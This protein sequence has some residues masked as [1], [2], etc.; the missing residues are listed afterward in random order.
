MKKRVFISGVT[1]TM[2]KSGLKHLLEHLDILEI[3]TLVRP[4]KTNKKIMSQ[5]AGSIDIIWGDLENYD[6]VKKALLNVDYILHVAALVSPMADSQP[7]LAYSVN[8]GS[9]KNIL[10]AISELNL[11]E[12]K[13]VNIGSVAQTGSRM[14]P[15]HW[16][17][18]GD[19]I[20]ASVDDYYATTKTIAERLVIESGLKYW[21]SLR[22]TGI[23]HYGLLNL[24]D[25]IMFHQPLDNVLEWVSEDDSGRLLA[26]ICLKDL[27]DDF[28]K[29]VYNIGGGEKCRINNYEF[30]QKMLKV[31]G[32]RDIEKI[33]EPQWFALKNFHG[34]F[35]LDSDKLNDFLDF[36][37]ESLDDFLIRLKKDVKLPATLLKYV[38]ANLTK[39]LIMKKIC[40]K[41]SGPLA[42]IKNNESEKIK[43]FYGSIDNFNN[44]PSWD[45]LVV[46]SNY[47]KKVI[48]DHGYNEAKTKLDFKDILKVAKFRGGYILSPPADFIN[49]DSQLLWKCAFN[50]KFKASVRLV[51][52]TGHFC[53]ECE[54]PPWN[55]K[56]IAKKNSFFDQVYK[57]ETQ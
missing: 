45:K 23:L 21:V 47:A 54:A 38:P 46:R 5:Y 53:P 39:N 9:I 35:Y 40:Q 3:V 4:S 34:Q 26:N 30:L 27:P 44:I 41:P 42:W 37:R 52:K 7:N 12:V 13:L 8:V 25:P 24:F 14:Y 18:V 55:Y 6:D 10:R 1:G 17:R 56:N 28:Y 48:L 29:N 33:F 43:A 51:L 32:V 2:G 57:K 50:H 36:R 31:I 19:P 20:K 22:Q 16:G 49:L 11:S 15:I